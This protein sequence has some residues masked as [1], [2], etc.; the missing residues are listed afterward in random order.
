MLLLELVQ[1]V[2]TMNSE[3]PGPVC[4]LAP[5]SLRPALVQNTDQPVSE[6]LFL[7]PLDLCFGFV[8]ALCFGPLVGMLGWGRCCSF[9]CF[10]ILVSLTSKDKISSRLWGSWAAP[11]SRTLAPCLPPRARTRVPI[12]PPSLGCCCTM[13]PAPAGTGSVGSGT[14]AGCWQA[15]S[16][17]RRSWQGP[18]A[19]TLILSLVVLVKQCPF[20]RIAVLVR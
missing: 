7:L 6:R 1:N 13:A 18:Q 16:L 19:P 4:L 5:P 3:S 2:I 10:S 12:A 11:L 8:A 9:L 15:A 14:G 17:P 20:G